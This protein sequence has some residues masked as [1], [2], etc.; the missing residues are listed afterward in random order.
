MFW[1]SQE[2]FDSNFI[3]STNPNNSTRVITSFSE[4]QYLELPDIASEIT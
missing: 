2:T 1:L 3:S 4:K